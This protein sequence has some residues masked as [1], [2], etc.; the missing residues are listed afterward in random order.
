MMGRMLL[1]SPIP[2]EEA[3]RVLAVVKELKETDG[4]VIGGSYVPCESP[5][6][7]AS[8]CRSR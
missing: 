2:A 8:R 6:W 1:N 4:G 7:C 3:E 5:R